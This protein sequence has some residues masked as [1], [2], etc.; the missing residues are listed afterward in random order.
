MNFL[1][2]LEL[3]K[4]PLTREYQIFALPYMVTKSI[5]YAFDMLR[6]FKST[7][8]KNS[9]VYQWLKPKFFFFRVQNLGRVVQND[10]NFGPRVGLGDD[11]NFGFGVGMLNFQYL[12]FLFLNPCQK[13]LPLPP[14]FIMMRWGSFLFLSLQ[15]YL[16]L[17]PN[18]FC[19]IP[20]LR[21]PP[22]PFFLNTTIELIDQGLV[23][24]LK[25]H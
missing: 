21:P 16:I 19:P 20:I 15:C 1:T 14:N 4:M 5:N 24:C 10:Q 9:T 13:I 18:T 6:V 11:Q 7:M 23:V 2:M 22:P 12:L 17:H 3:Y 8:P 25:T